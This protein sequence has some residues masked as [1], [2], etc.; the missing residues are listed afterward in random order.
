MFSL[1]NLFQMYFDSNIT[2]RRS[3]KAGAATHTF[4]REYFITRDCK[5][6]SSQ[7]AMKRFESEP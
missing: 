6:N 3:K 7:S 1:P 5:L 2:M 4:T